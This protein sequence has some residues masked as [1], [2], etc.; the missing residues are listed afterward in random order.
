VY[1]CKVW[2]NSAQLG[3]VML[4]R[5]AE[6]TI[7]NCSFGNNV[8]SLGKFYNGYNGTR[9]SIIEN[10]ILWNPSGGLEIQ[11]VVGTPFI[12]N[13][14]IVRGGYGNGTG[15]TTTDPLYINAATGDL[16]L[17][18]ASPAINGGVNALIHIDAYDVDYDGNITEVVDI[19]LDGTLRVQNTTIDLGA[20]EFGGT[21]DEEEIEKTV[22][23]KVYPN[24][25]G[26]GTNVTVKRESDESVEL[27]VFNALGQIVL[28][29]ETSGS[30]TILDTS[31]WLPGVYIIRIGEETLRAVKSN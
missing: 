20:F 23:S 29:S 6:A 15:I 27:T 18:S 16:R 12:V 21:L 31:D 7:T 9:T 4:L 1:N 14:S 8:G 24:P 17:N 3:A 26:S 11:N 10:C 25:F 2:N 22:V 19:D 28:R 13:N 30:T 5:D